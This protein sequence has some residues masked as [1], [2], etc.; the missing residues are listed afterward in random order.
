MRAL[1]DEAAAYVRRREPGI[2]VV[3][4]WVI[5]VLASV[6]PIRLPPSVNG[7]CYYCQLMVS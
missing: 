6:V 3:E 4:Y 2:F 5:L 1:A 7:S